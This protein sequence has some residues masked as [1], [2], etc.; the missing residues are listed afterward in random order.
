MFLVC[1]CTVQEL[2]RNPILMAYLT[3]IRLIDL[4]SCVVVFFVCSLL[5]SCTIV[6]KPYGFWWSL[7]F[8][9]CTYNLLNN[10]YLIG[11][12]TNSQVYLW[13]VEIEKNGWFM[14]K[15]RGIPD[16]SL[17][18]LWLCWRSHIDL[19]D[20]IAANTHTHAH[21]HRNVIYALFNACMLY[22]KWIEIL[23]NQQK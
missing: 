8:T 20:I 9:S 14:F 7:T 10:I 17:N 6:Y 12:R 13:I 16:F 19:L 3:A 2:Q 15:P 5:V 11:I 23:P 22:W 4:V 18:R 1:G 21:R